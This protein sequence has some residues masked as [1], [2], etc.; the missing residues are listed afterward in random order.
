M[1]KL[2]KEELVSLGNMLACC[3]G[4]R[5]FIIKTY[6]QKSL[7]MQ[8]FVNIDFEEMLFLIR[9]SFTTGKLEFNDKQYS[10]LLAFA[11]AFDAVIDS[12]RSKRVKKIKSI[13]KF[14]RETFNESEY[15]IITKSNNKLH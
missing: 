4:I 11:M 10:A 12:Y 8:D 6:S 15:N 5:E 14:L 13:V 1:K 3:D 2:K 7:N 9:K